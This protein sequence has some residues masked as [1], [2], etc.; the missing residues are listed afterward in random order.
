MVKVRLDISLCFRWVVVACFVMGAAPG[1]VRAQRIVGDQAEALH[2]ME[3]VLLFGGDV[4]EVHVGTFPGRRDLL[5]MVTDRLKAGS[6]PILS[7]RD[8]TMTPGSP[9]LYIEIDAWPVGEGALAYGIR[10]EV[11]EL[12]TPLA[13]P[14]QATY[15]VVW[16]ARDAGSLTAGEPGPLL[17]AVGA[18]ADKL[19]LDFHTAN[20][21]TH[22]TR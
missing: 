4:P 7:E 22:G 10:F 5:E 19:V 18:L 8:W 13:A 3:G 15:G 20:P 11:Q 6:V 1:T 12:V 14:D 16:S 2:R 21:D 9:V 17:A